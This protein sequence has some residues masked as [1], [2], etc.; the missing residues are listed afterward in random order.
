MDLLTTK[1]VT[2]A[3][4]FARLV[5]GRINHRRKYTGEPYFVHLE[6]VARIVAATPGATEEMVAASYLHDS[7]EDAGVL[8]GVIRQMFGDAVAGYVDELTD[9]FTPES[10]HG[11]RA[12]R[13]RLEC[14][15]LAQVSSGAQTIKVADLISNT[16]SICQH[17]KAFAV[18]YLGEKEQLLCVLTRADSGL[19]LQ[20]RAVIS[21]GRAALLTS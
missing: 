14:N 9:R 19:L 5:H 4:D 21:Q 3:S 6:E 8:V 2:R 7:I 10:G 1:L 17:D 11:N 15:R 16:S 18:V 20:A 12:T 13:K